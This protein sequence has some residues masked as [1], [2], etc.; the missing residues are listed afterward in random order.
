MKKLKFDNPKLT[1]MLLLAV[2][3]L[4]L[5]DQS[6]ISQERSLSAAYKDFFPI[7]AAISPRFLTSKDTLILVENFNSITAENSMKPASL[8]PKEGEWNWEGADKL[9]NFAMRHGMKIRGH[10]LVWHNQTPDWFFKDGEQPAS[11]ELLL[12]RMKNH[13]F[14]VM[15]HFKGEVYCWDVVNEAISD[16][17][18]ETYRIKD[19]KWFQIAGEDFIIKAF[20]YAH[21][22]D[23]EAI[24]FY[25]DYNCTNPGKM[26][27]ICKMI[28]NLK[29]KGVTVHG[30]GLQAHWSIYTP[31]ENELKTAIDRYSELGLIIQLTELDLSVYK[32]E[33]DARKSKD[34]VDM[35]F[36][37]EKQKL[38]ADQYDMIFRVL[39]EKKDLITG[40]TFW[41]ISDKYSWLNNFP[42]PGRKNYPLLFD[43]EMTPKESYFRIIDF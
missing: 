4:S 24:L 7:G 5:T 28:E 14:K 38:Q 9:V 12:A 34:G 21:E 37:P 22:A 11:K 23:P 10:C 18:E 41:G 33:E 13:I 8:Q 26:E 25:N 42:V 30:M 31:T 29:K 19:S 2:T 17:P 1:I 32:W 36:T 35:S 3:S 20:E 15:E 39:R 16:N 43:D 6:Y 27:K 40:V